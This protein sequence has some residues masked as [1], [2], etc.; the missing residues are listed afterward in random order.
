MT[1]E[2]ATPTGS[3]PST[4]DDFVT[5]GWAEHVNGEHANSEASFRKAL[6]LNAQS[7]EAYYGLAMAL[8]SQNQL[9]PATEAFEKVVAGI[10]ADQMKNDPARASILRNL[11]NTQIEFIRKQSEPNS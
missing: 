4:A 10:N 1:P 5:Q 6:E 9:Q 7:I 8:K 11:A 3:N 2:N